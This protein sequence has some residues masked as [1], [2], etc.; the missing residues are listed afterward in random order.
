MKT[1]LARL[2]TDR[3]LGGIPKNKGF[4]EW[5]NGRLEPKTDVHVEPYRCCAA[6]P[7]RFLAKAA[8]ILA[9]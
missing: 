3:A 9:I 8:K 4:S 2:Q 7:K 5:S 6:S 1:A